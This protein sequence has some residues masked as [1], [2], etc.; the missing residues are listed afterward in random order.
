MKARYWKLADAPDFGG[1][2]EQWFFQGVG[3]GINDACLPQEDCFSP[4]LFR[5]TLANRKDLLAEAYA[6]GEKNKEAYH[7]G[8]WVGMKASTQ[9]LSKPAYGPPAVAER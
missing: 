3:Q 2:P 7:Q 1:T 6:R 9:Y 4:E 5:E 8:Y